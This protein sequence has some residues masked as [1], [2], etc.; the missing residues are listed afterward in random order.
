MLFSWR[1]GDDERVM[2]VLGQLPPGVATAHPRLRSITLDF[3]GL[4]PAVVNDCHRI[5]SASGVIVAGPGSEEGVIELDPARHRAAPSWAAYGNDDGT[6][7][8]HCEHCGWSFDAPDEI[9]LDQRRTAH[10]A[11]VHGIAGR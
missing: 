4:P 7:S 8:A 11:R 5:M 9:A 10:D 6:R 3:R 2:E 1:A